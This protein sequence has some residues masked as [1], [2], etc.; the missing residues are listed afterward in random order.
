MVVFVCLH[1]CIHS[2]NEVIWL[3]SSIVCVFMSLRVLCESECH[4]IITQV[5][6]VCACECTRELHD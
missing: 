4:V 3:Y 5:F 2:P 6:C 1:V